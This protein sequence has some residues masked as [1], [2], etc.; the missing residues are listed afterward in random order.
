[1]EIVDGTF[2]IL[3]KGTIVGRF[4]VHDG[5]HGNN[6]ITHIPSGRMVFG[7]IAFKDRAIQAAK[8]LDALPI[9]WDSETPTAGSAMQEIKE[10]AAWARSVMQEIKEIAAWAEGG[11]DP[12][13]CGVNSWP[14]RGRE[15]ERR[16]DIH[17]EFVEKPTCRR[18][19]HGPTQ[20]QG[21]HGSFVCRKQP[22]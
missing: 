20:G 17:S 10:I 18:N 14:G 22:R 3:M 16:E 1:M 7:D 21:A 11:C 8:Q 15:E 19:A 5:F 6:T 4:G 12:T 2:K 13:W 9:D